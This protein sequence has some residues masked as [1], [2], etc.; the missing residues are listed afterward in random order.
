MPDSDRYKI[1]PH[2]F[3]RAVVNEFLWEPGSQH[4]AFTKC[5]V[6][7][8]AAGPKA[9]GDNMIFGYFTGIPTIGAYALSR[10]CFSHIISL[11]QTI[12]NENGGHCLTIL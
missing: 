2:N 4:N 10:K 9:F 7:A 11:K 5:E 3:G 1:P 6:L 8:H 12:R